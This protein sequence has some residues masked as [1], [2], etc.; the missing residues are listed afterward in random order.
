MVPHASLFLGNLHANCFFAAPEVLQTPGS[1]GVAA[2]V[3]SIASIFVWCVTGAAPCVHMSR[4]LLGLGC[5][6]DRARSLV[7]SL[8]S[9]MHEPVQIGDDLVRRALPPASRC[10]ICHIMRAGARLQRCQCCCRR[11]VR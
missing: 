2:D 8:I 10:L 1:V 6:S 7:P 4:E 3:F 9:S 11:R 5:Y